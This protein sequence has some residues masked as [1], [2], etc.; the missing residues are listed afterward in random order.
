MVFFQ[1]FSSDDRDV[2]TK[3]LDTLVEGT[4]MLFEHD[5]KEQIARADVAPSQPRV[6]ETT[7]WLQRTNWMSAFAGVN[8]VEA[9][10]LAEVLPYRKERHPTALICQAI[11]KLILRA[12]MGA[13][14]NH[15]PHLIR[16]LLAST[17][18]DHVNTDPANFSVSFKTLGTYIRTW[19][20]MIVYLFRARSE[21]TTYKLQLNGHQMLALAV[22]ANHT[23]EEPVN[24]EALVSLLLKFSIDLITQPLYGHA[25]D[26]P[27]VHFL[28]VLGFH[29]TLKMWRLPHQYTPYLSHLLYCARVLSLEHCLPAGQRGDQKQMV[30]EFRKFHEQHLVDSSF[31][32]VT[33]LI[34]L[35][36]YGMVIAKEHHSRERFY[37]S[38]DRQT[39]YFDDTTI[40]V[41]VLRSLANSVLTEAQE[42]LTSRLVFRDSSYLDSRDA[43]HFRDNINNTSNRWCFLQLPGNNLLNGARRV[44]GWLLD[45]TFSQQLIAGK[46]DSRRWAH[47]GIH[48]YHKAVDEFLAMLFVLIHLTSGMPARG[49]EVTSMKIAN[50]MATTRNFYIHDGQ[51]MT[52]TE[53][54]KPQAITGAPMVISR[55]L[56]AAVGQL[57]IAYVADVLPFSTLLRQ[58]VRSTQ[59]RSPVLFSGYHGTWDTV[60][61]TSHLKKYSSEYLG[62]P[63]TMSGW[64][65][66]SVAIDKGFSLGFLDDSFSLF[67]H[68]EQELEPDVNIVAAYQTGHRPAIH[69]RLYGQS[70]HLTDGAMTLTRGVS[71]RLHGFW[72]LKSRHDDRRS[73]VQNPVSPTAVM[74][75]EEAMQCLFP[76]SGAWRSSAQEE[77]VGQSQEPLTNNI[78]V[79]PTGAGKS[80]IFMVLA[81]MF[82]SSVQVVVIPYQALLR[83]MINRCSVA[84]IQADEWTGGVNGHKQLIFVSTEAAV[85]DEFLRVLRH[86]KELGHLGRIFIDECHTLI[87]AK[88]YRD[89]MKEL[90][91]LRA[92][93]QGITFM[94]ATLPK[95]VE[96]ELRQA[97]NLD[98]A[99]VL[100]APT[101][102]LATKYVV[103]VEDP[104]LQRLLE[105]MNRIRGLPT[106]GKII[107]FV[108]SLQ[109]CEQVGAA[110]EAPI[111][112]SNYP[113]KQA[114][115]DRWSRGSSPIIVATSALGQGVDVPNV[116]HVFHFDNP[117]LNL[118]DF[119]Q[120]S[121]RAGREGQFCSSIIIMSRNTKDR[122][123]RNPA[124]NLHPDEQAAVRGFLQQSACRRTALSMFLDDGSKDICSQLPNAMPCD[125]CDLQEIGSQPPDSFILPFLGQA[126][127][128]ERRVDRPPSCARPTVQATPQVER[129]PP[130]TPMPS[131]QRGDRS[132][133]EAQAPL[134][135]RRETETDLTAF[136]P[137]RH[138]SLRPSKLASGHVLD[139]ETPSTRSSK[140]EEHT[141]AT[142]PLT[143]LGSTPSCPSLLPATPL[144]ALVSDSPMGVIP[145]S[146]D[147]SS[148][149]PSPCGFVP[150][151]F[152]FTTKA[153]YDGLPFTERNRP[154]GP[155]ASR[156]KT[157]PYDSSEQ[158]GQRRIERIWNMLTLGCVACWV[159][160]NP[161][162]REHRLDGC[163]PSRSLFEDM[164]SVRSQM[165]FK[166]SVVHFACGAP[167]WICDQF[168]NRNCSYQNITYPLLGAIFR[169]PRFHAL[170]STLAKNDFGGFE[171]TTAYSFWLTSNTHRFGRP[172]PNAISLIEQV[173]LAIE[174]PQADPSV[175]VE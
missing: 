102:R 128:I 136:A 57:Y 119:I 104:A 111:F 56:P 25:H 6:I 43:R 135:R 77:A 170:L 163:Q 94:T 27:F 84:G 152:A 92:L 20:S 87:L 75:V 52:V 158:Q 145:N 37:W 160:G 65:Q 116:T 63:L 35:R 66:I 36:A 151:R 101:T 132:S 129:P 44:C 130:R 73:A 123:L 45:S 103:E 80:A 153:G 58:V 16:R 109:S 110:L 68:D 85:T 134:K 48:A 154:A 29:P 5:E 98:S 161:D 76:P 105:W 38:S 149:A 162:W 150:A 113:D 155:Q 61:L 114:S 60:T 88:H 47:A 22:I 17:T 53:Y 70:S 127:S 8:M 148:M 156:P 23:I 78:T 59:A 167:I 69:H 46:D 72:A 137:T 24:M 140:A 168:R 4:L 121:G 166:S 3:D 9:C 133:L 89:S 124:P 159:S 12:H 41:P 1:V 106:T 125:L 122:I 131:I 143:S 144:P 50:T 138:P 93:S 11:E 90:S 139:A 171:D 146:T 99:Y 175:A 126:S 30:L 91:R 165:H 115:F 96:L 42:L 172:V 164:S 28:G 108:A 117:Y 95:Y 79:L 120:Q 141:P 147:S 33:E 83:E 86:F 62:V 2:T 18:T 112:Y 26:S 142:S 15:C 67:D 10:S 157:P 21:R 49:T 39:L 13:T 71:A 74:S 7:P 82:P 55:W 31:S 107:V 100:R 174:G 81:L 97:F 54:H 118:T 34:S 169:T 173:Y 64:R 14:T 51:V 40:N 32:A 19:Q